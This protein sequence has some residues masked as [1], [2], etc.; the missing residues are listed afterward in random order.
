MPW[1]GPRPAVPRRPLRILM[2][3][4]WQ[5]AYAAMIKVA[6]PYP[7]DLPARRV[8]ISVRGQVPKKPKL[9][10]KP[11]VLPVACPPL[12][13][14]NL[15]PQCWIW[16][17]WM[18]KSFGPNLVPSGTFDDFKT[19]S[20]LEAAGWVDVSRNSPDITTTVETVLAKDKKRRVLR[21][22]VLAADTNRIDRL[23]PMLDFPQA[24]IRSPEVKVKAG[25]F[26]RISVDIAKAMYHPEGHSG[27]IIRD[28][29]GGEPLQ[30]RTNQVI[31]DLTPV[32]LFR[33][34]PAD[35]VMSV[36]LGLAC[37]GEAFFNNF[38]VEVVEGP[39]AAQPADL[40]GLAPRLPDPAAP[41][42]ARPG[43]AAR[44]AAVPRTNR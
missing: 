43:T 35:G 39:G 1:P 11:I 5:K 27:L 25:Q 9:P 16:I 12:V 37:Y 10:P 18:R 19:L 14:F 2:F 32:V 24:A 34:A 31:Y 22:S 30:F 38:K 36:T 6:V 3:A 44:P 4:H 40:A 8:P 33:R 20:A 21:L 41:V 26:I 7:E 15:L 17:D 13:G 29:I 42:P 23:P 28:S